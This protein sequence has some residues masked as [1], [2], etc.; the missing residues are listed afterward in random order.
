MKLRP[1]Q[2]F[3][4]CV[5]CSRLNST[6]LEVSVFWNILLLHAA[7]QDGILSAL[8]GHEKLWLS[9]LQGAFPTPVTHDCKCSGWVGMPSQVSRLLDGAIGPLGDKASDW[10]MGL[11]WRNASSVMGDSMALWGYLMSKACRKT[12]AEFF[13]YL[14]PTWPLFLLGKG[15]VL[16]GWPSKIEALEVSWVLGMLWFFCRKYREALGLYDYLDK[17]VVDWMSMVMQA[18]LRSFLPLRQ[19]SSMPFLLHAGLSSRKNLALCLSGQ[20]RGR[21]SV[22]DLQW[23][24]WWHNPH[25]GIF[26]G[27]LQFQTSDCGVAQRPLGPALWELWHFCRGAFRGLANWKQNFS[28][29]LEVVSK[30]RFQNSTVGPTVS[31][32]SWLDQLFP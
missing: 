30:P 13:K 15:I 19:R 4:G 22:A 12:A 26:W 1:D 21:N 10:R 5:W 28:L 29:D 14:E 25:G 6:A 17:R 31:R 18:A 32:K 8:G 7:A 24:S 23:A 3:T 9:T 27:N 2:T 20:L 11:A 16:E